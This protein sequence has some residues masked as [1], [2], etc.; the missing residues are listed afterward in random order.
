MTES[1]VG[2]KLQA[3]HDYAWY[4]PALTPRGTTSISLRPVPGRWGHEASALSMFF[5]S[6]RRA[7]DADTLHHSYGN[8]IS[9]RNNHLANCAFLG[10]CRTC[11]HCLNDRW[12]RGLTGDNLRICTICP[13]TVARSVWNFPDGGCTASTLMLF[14]KDTVQ[15]KP[16]NSSHTD[17]SRQVVDTK[18]CPC[19]CDMLLE[20]VSSGRAPLIM[21]SQATARSRTKDQAVLRRDHT[22]NRGKV[23]GGLQAPWNRTSLS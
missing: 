12:C 3:E 15:S 11:V 20:G 14:L 9:I 5:H 22:W 6:W 17:Q 4:V 18:T 23:N 10:T 8:R 19:V 2:W 21:Y 16:G 1:Q 7:D 13:W